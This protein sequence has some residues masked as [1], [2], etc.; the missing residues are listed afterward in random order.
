MESA[1][2]ETLRMNGIKEFDRQM[3]KKKLKQIYEDNAGNISAIQ[4]KY[5]LTEQ[6]ESLL[7]E[8]KEEAA[9]EE[10]NGKDFL[11]GFTAKDKMYQ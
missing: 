5:R 1:Y 7:K 10:K 4:R 9:E 2:V 11:M 6:D 8:I 3:A